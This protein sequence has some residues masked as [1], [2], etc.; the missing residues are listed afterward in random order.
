MNK[1]MTKQLTK[2][3][4]KQLNNE[5]NKD[6]TKQLNN[7]MNKDMNKQINKTN[8]TNQTNILPQTLT[9][10]FQAAFPSLS[11]HTPRCAGSWSATIAQ[12]R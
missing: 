5:M 4:N 6:M 1:D 11:L 10:N 3:L 2:Q 9:P 12:S 8:L 7:E